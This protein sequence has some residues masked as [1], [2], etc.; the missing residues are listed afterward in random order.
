MLIDSNE[1]VVRNHCNT[2]IEYAKT[3]NKNL[4]FSEASLADVEE[5]LDC[6]F[7]DLSSKNPALDEIESLA[8]IWGIYLGEVVRIHN[9]ERCHW[10]V[11]DV[12][13]DGAELYLQIEHIKAFPIYKVYKRL[14]NGPE[15][16]VMSFYDVIKYRV[17]ER[18]RGS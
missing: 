12:L 1:D 8:I 11:D 2:A 14:T 3:L 6:Y 18:N 9:S 7:E 17:I 13:G 16:N 5:I 10:Q 15:D 4:D